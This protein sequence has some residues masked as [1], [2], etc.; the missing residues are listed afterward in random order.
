MPSAATSASASVMATSARRNERA[1]ERRCIGRSSGLRDP[2]GSYPRA[3]LLRRGYDCG[4]AVKWRATM[5]RMSLARVWRRQ[6]FGASSAALIVPAAMFAALVVLALG[7]GFSQVGV[8]GQI[9]A[10]PSAPS[11]GGAPAGEHGPA[12]ARLTAGALPV[13]PAGAGL[14]T[15]PGS[16]RSGASGAVRGGGTPSSPGAPSR[17]GGALG[18]G[19]PITGGGAGGPVPRPSPPSAPSPGPGGSAPPAPSSPGPPGPPKP[20]PKPGP[21]PFDQIVGAVTPVTQQVPAPAGPA[22]T[23]AV[24]AADRAANGLLPPGAGSGAPVPSKSPALP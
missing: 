14:R 16:R 4:A 19:A 8:L 2:G 5:P 23:Q 15:G 6:L 10:G 18:G 22:A 12:P 11:L 1:M 17:T 21:T 24:Q 9:F 20:Q 13:I 7:G 3:A